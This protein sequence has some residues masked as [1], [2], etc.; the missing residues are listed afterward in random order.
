MIDQHKL[1]KKLLQLCIL[2]S[3]AAVILSYRAQKKEVGLCLVFGIRSGIYLSQAAPDR[4]GR[5][6]QEAVAEKIKRNM[7]EVEVLQGSFVHVTIH[8]EEEYRA[9]VNCL[10]EYVDCY[11]L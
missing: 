4:I 6:V 3:L 5:R 11:S 1:L 10:E 8:N 9:F 2:I 7:P